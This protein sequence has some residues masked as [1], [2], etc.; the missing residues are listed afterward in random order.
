MST[1]ADLFC[2]RAIIGDIKK[3]KEVHLEGKLTI[4]RHPFIAGRIENFFD[5]DNRLPEQISNFLSV[6]KYEPM[7]N[8]MFQF[9]Q[10]AD[11]QK[12]LSEFKDGGDVIYNRLCN[13]LKDWLKLAF[14]WDLNE[15][16][17]LTS[18]RYRKGDFLLCHNDLVGGHSNEYRKVAFVYYFGKDFHNND[19]GSLDLYECDCN[20]QPTSIVHSLYPKHNSLAFFEVS[21][22]SYHQVSEIVC[23]RERLS[24]HGWFHGP[25]VERYP[26]FIE[27]PRRLHE[28]SSMENEDFVD[29][30]NPMY[31]EPE[32][33]A[34][35]HELL[36]SKERNMNDIRLPNFLNQ[37]FFEAVTSAFAEYNKWK[38]KGPANRRNYYVMDDDISLNNHL[39]TALLTCRGLK[40]VNQK[41]Y[42]FFLS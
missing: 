29:L 36:T 6:V 2:D 1:I 16:V 12:S 19:G 7:Y 34:Q 9:E 10:S 18:S 33:Q 41:S 38:L 20:N 27:P 17:R 28:F 25:S 23:D 37:R 26:L 15:R 42:T 22:K 5:A 32:I 21:D 14:G 8:D 31:L 39:K 13:E 3:G 30:V 4:Y 24:I 40:R 35:I 11:I